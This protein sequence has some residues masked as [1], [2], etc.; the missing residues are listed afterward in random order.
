MKNKLTDL[1]NS[2]RDFLKKSSIAFLG[3]SILPSHVISG[4]GHIAPS[5][6]LNIAG[7]GVGE[8]CCTL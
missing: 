2:R 6:K 3:V 8:Y 4:L 1:N 7:I 5:D